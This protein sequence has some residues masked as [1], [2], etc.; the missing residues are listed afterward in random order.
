M[1]ITNSMQRILRM[2]SVTFGM[3]IALRRMTKMSLVFGGVAQMVMAWAQK[4]EF[5]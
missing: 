3:I 2:L 5:R 4:V 1:N